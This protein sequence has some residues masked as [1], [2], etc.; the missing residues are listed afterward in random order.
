MTKPFY[1]LYSYDKIANPPLHVQEE[2]NRILEKISKKV[3]EYKIIDFGSGTGRLTIPLL[4]NNYK[5]TAVDIDNFSLKHLRSNAKK[6]KRINNLKIANKIV[7]KNYY[8]F[9]VGA[10]VLHHVNMD[11]IL[12]FFYESLNKKGKIIFS[13]P[14]AL[15]LPWWFFVLFV[16]GFNNEKGMIFCNYFTLLNML[17]KASFKKIKISGFGLFPPQMFMNFS[18]FHKINFYLGNLPFFKIFAFRFIIEAQK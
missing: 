6:N 18:F 2:I 4:K 9:I 8:S 1:L 12:P 5:V 3:P 14:N 15:H 7:K 10:D 16:S 11:K 17:K 13:E